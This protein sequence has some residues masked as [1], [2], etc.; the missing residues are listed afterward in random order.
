[1]LNVNSI[2]YLLA[3]GNA[4]LSSESVRSKKSESCRESSEIDLSP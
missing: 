3:V 2:P 4:F 1:M